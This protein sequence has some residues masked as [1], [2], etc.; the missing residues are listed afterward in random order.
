MQAHVCMPGTMLA[1]GTA[2]D[3]PKP[4]PYLRYGARVGR[5]S[6]PP[7]LLHPTSTPLRAT[8]KRARLLYQCALDWNYADASRSFAN[9]SQG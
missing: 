4:L 2:L 7:F 8:L 3:T 9:R 1:Y 6:V 5:S